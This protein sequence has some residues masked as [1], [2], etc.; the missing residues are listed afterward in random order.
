ML[1]D[2]LPGLIN[3]EIACRKEDAEEPHKREVFIDPDGTIRADGVRLRQSRHCS[4]LLYELIR[5]DFVHGLYGFVLF[6]RWRRQPPE[7]PYQAVGRLV[8]A[9]NGIFK[10]EGLD[11]QIE[12]ET[13]D[14]PRW[15]LVGLEALRLTG[16][17]ID[18][19]RLLYQT[20]QSQAPEVQPLDR[21]LLIVEAFHADSRSADAACALVELR[22][23]IP[24]ERLPTF[25]QC[26]H[27]WRDVIARLRGQSTSYENWRRLI[28]K[29]L[30]IF[31]SP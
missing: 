4:L 1:A 25:Q 16:G 18:A 20:K 7:D 31:W 3:A 17:V 12:R 24:P 9:L 27:C 6:D 11:F 26:F 28:E 13:R 10:N 19:K 29:Y 2:A 30:T 22:E 15:R 8:W 5:H 14:I 21:A 23:S